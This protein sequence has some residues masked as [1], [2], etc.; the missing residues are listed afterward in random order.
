MFHW[1]R[2]CRRKIIPNGI[3]VWLEPELHSQMFALKFFCSEF[4]SDTR[5]VFPD[6]RSRWSSGFICEAEG[7]EENQGAAP[8]QLPWGPA[9]ARHQRCGEG[10]WAGD[11]A[12]SP[13]PEAL[14]GFTSTQRCWRAASGPAGKRRHYPCPQLPG[15]RAGDRAI[16]SAAGRAGT[17]RCRCPSRCPEPCPALP[18]PAGEPLDARV[19]VNER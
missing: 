8:A 11:G 12:I 6:T 14:Q 13:T 3:S 18:E 9:Q 5:S 15:R 2:A 10:P 19:S 4:Y 1:K 7:A 17:C 16:A